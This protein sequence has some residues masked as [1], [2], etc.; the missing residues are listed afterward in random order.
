M[1][2]RQQAEMTAHLDR[3]KRA[4]AKRDRRAEEV[5]ERVK[6]IADELDPPDDDARR[7][8]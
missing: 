3:I 5:L 6:A 8:E 2:A 7:R 1:T 4:F